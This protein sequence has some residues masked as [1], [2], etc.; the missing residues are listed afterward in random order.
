MKRAFQV[1]LL[2]LMTQTLFYADISLG[3]SPRPQVEKTQQVQGKNWVEPETGMEFIWIPGGT[4]LMGCDARLHDCDLDEEPVHKV[5]LEGFWIGKTEVTQKQWEQVMGY[6]PSH[7]NK[8]GDYPVENISWINAQ[9]FIRRLAAASDMKYWYS[10]PSEAQWEYACRSG[11]GK[12]EYSGG[13]SPNG[14]AW[15]MENSGGQTHPVAQKSPN[16]LG[17]YD[18][19]GNVWEW[20]RDQYDVKAYS[21]HEPIDPVFRGE[22]P[23]RVIRGGAW[24]FPTFNVRCGV[25]NDSS[26]GDGY[27]DIGFRV[28]RSH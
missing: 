21:K 13:A 19:S 24:N 22:E 17:I 27:Y 1:I 7:F 23:Y 16:A 4:F 15:F 6:N 12:D 14:S 5:E 2:C 20:C 8:G 18:L 26:P 25:R 9:E 3:M 10:L 28:V 11:G